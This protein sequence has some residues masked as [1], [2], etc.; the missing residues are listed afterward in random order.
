MNQLILISE[1]FD[2][3]GKVA[4]VLPLGE[5]MINTTYKVKLINNTTEYVLQKINHSIFKDVEVL[6]GN[7]KR[8]TNYIRYKLIEAGETDINRKTVTIIPTLDDKLYHFDGEYYW[9]IMLLINE[10]FTY[11]AVTPEYAYSAG[12]AFGKF[13]YM[14]TD[15][16]G[17]EY[18]KDLENINFN[19]EIFK[20]YTK[21]YLE[22]AHEFLTPIEIEL[23]PFGACLM[24]YMQLSRFLA[25]YLNG[26]IYYKINE[27]L[28]NLHRSRA[29][30]KLL[31]S[32]EANYQAMQSFIDEQF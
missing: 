10:S 31:T 12:L 3:V 5:G 18:D 15:I 25:D 7:I 20:S 28:H 24:T 29:Q 32:I 21:G 23:L 16:H 2:L 19:L 13:Q 14:L 26:D 17:K 9:R 30:Y 22:T 8:I 1:Q 6:Q 27:P 11:Q 4:E